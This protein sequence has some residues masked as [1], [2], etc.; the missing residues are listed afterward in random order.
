MALVFFIFY[1]L[2]SNFSKT[3]NDKTYPEKLCP[4]PFDPLDNHENM[5]TI[6]HQFCNKN[7]YEP[8]WKIRILLIGTFNPHGGQQ[9]NYY[10]GRESNKTWELLSILFKEKFDPTNP[11]LFFKKIE[12]HGIGCMDI[13]DNVKAE[14]ERLDQILGKGYKDTKIINGSVK[15]QYNTRRIIKVIEDNPRVNIYSTWGK[16]STLKEWK[17]E[18]SKIK[19]LIPLVSPSMAA[20]V[21]KGTKKFDYML[22]DWRKKIRIN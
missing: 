7:F 9:V 3:E 15:R 12:K 19:N 11:D 20:R 22:A 5:E 8:N 16:G 1:V 4:V 6:Q 21:P 13:I 2:H 14:K 18:T 17:T 10:Y